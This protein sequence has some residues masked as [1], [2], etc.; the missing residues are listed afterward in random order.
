MKAAAEIDTQRGHRID[1]ELGSIAEALWLKQ[2]RQVS[3]QGYYVTAERAGDPDMAATHGA[4]RAHEG[5]LRQAVADQLV[6]RR[7]IYMDMDHI[8]AWGDADCPSAPLFRARVQI[9][10]SMPR[11]RFGNDTP[12]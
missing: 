9:S 2:D 1:R 3:Q 7:G 11:K 12:A 8:T 4:D 10:R 6:R 5:N